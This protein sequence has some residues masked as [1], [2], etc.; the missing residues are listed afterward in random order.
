MNRSLAVATIFV[1][2]QDELW[3]VLETRM[4]WD[5]TGA[6][7]C[8][9]D[10]KRRMRVEVEDDHVWLTWWREEIRAIDVKILRIST[11]PVAHV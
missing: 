4:V 1:R 10:R 6:C 11:E 2:M 5:S 8:T 7:G 9:R 3:P